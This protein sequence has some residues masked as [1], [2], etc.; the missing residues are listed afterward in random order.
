MLAIVCVQLHA[1]FHLR[2]LVKRATA[3]E[4]GQGGGHFSMLTRQLS[5]CKKG[6]HRASGFPS[7]GGW[8]PLELTLVTFVL[9]LGG[10]WSFGWW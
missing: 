8:L 7:G 2:S 1:N 9:L 10:C 6:T 3:H 4:G 5:V